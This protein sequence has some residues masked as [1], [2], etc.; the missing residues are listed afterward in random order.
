MSTL[1]SLLMDLSLFG[2]NER[3]FVDVWMGLE[4]RVIAQFKFVLSS[5]RVFSS[6]SIRVTRKDVERRLTYPLAVIE[7][8]DASSIVARFEGWRGDETMSNL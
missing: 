5:D 6:A 1:K 3:A 2:P 8:H 4:V 7:S